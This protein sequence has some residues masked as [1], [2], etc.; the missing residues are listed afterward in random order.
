MKLAQVIK[1]SSQYLKTAVLVVS[2]CLMSNAVLCPGLKR[3]LCVDVLNALSTQM[4][5][6]L[7]PLRTDS[8]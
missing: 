5:F 6:P 8:M 1:F 3:A 4:S 2:F 7:M